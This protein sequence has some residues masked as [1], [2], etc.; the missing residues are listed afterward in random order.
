MSNL[1]GEYRFVY[2]VPVLEIQPNMCKGNIF[3]YVTAGNGF[4]K[5]IEKYL[6]E[7]GFNNYEIIDEELLNIIAEDAE[8]FKKI[9]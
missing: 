7:K 9:F 3:I 2:N 8:Q 6:L 4:Q 1:Q 5:E